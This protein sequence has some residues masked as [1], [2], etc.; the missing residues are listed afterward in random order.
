MTEMISEQQEVMRDCVE[1]VTRELDSINRELRC[2]ETKKEH[3][4]NLLTVTF[5]QAQALEKSSIQLPG[6]DF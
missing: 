1:F 6:G 4:K 2:L 5:T 3:L